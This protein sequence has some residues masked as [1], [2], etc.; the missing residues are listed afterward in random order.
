MCNLNIKLR[1]ENNKKNSALKEIFQQKTLLYSSK[2]L[3]SDHLID[4]VR[5]QRLLLPSYELIYV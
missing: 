3:S 1:I 2:N 4:A 5:C